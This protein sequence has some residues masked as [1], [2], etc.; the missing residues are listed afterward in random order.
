MDFAEPLVSRDTSISCKGPAQPTLPSVA[1]NEA[2]DTG[3]DDESLEHHR[4]RCSAESLIEELQDRH[5]RGRPRH[6]RQI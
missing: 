5:I 6:G 1:R 2:S 3:T 4:S